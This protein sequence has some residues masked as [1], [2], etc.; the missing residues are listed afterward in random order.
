MFIN[1]LGVHV[2]YFEKFLVAVFR[3]V[4]GD[5]EDA[6]LLRDVKG[7]IGQEAQ[8]AFNFVGWNKVMHKTCRRVGDLEA[9][10]EKH[11]EALRARR[12]RP[13]CNQQQNHVAI[14]WRSLGR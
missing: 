2:P 4:R 7:I 10:A 13:I 6:K 11:F 9:D 12:N 3:D 1:A 14:A 8:H 5:I